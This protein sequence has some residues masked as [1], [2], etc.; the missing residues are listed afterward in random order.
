M[1]KENVNKKKRWESYFPISLEDF[2]IETITEEYKDYAIFIETYR[3]F[4]SSEVKSVNLFELLDK[5]FDNCIKIKY[6]K[7]PAK[8]LII[9]KTQVSDAFLDRL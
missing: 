3:L 4:S 2:L 6:V 7:N 9:Q 8:Y 5:C 1:N